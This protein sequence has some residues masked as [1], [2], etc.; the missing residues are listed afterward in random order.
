MFGFL[1]SM[2]VMR[3]GLCLLVVGSHVGGIGGFRD[4]HGELERRCARVFG[5]GTQDTEDPREAV[6]RLG[7]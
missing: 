7:G 1:L 3:L 6:A 5:L 2:G 4:H